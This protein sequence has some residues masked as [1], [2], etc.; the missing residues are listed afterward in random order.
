[1][2]DVECPGVLYKLKSLDKLK[3]RL[4]KD[5]PTDA[6]LSKRKFQVRLKENKSIKQFILEVSTDPF[7]F[8]LL[9]EEQVCVKKR[10]GQGQMK[11]PKK[12]QKNKQKI[13][14]I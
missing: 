13:S 11:K 7:G 12:I 8:N 14:K 9:S 5:L 6:L 3:D 2:L 4:S 1:L 10:Q